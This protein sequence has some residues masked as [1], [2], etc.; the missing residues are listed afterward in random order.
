MIKII[1]L[2]LLC[3]L[4]MFLSGCV[5]YLPPVADFSTDIS[6]GTAPLTVQF[7]DNS[8]DPDGYI[9]SW[10]WDFD[11]GNTS[12]HQEGG[13]ITHTFQNEGSYRVKLTV[14]D[15]EGHTD[16]TYSYV[17]VS[18]SSSMESHT[19]VA[20]I[21]AYVSQNNPENNYGLQ[22]FLQV[23]GNDYIYLKFTNI[24][25]IET[26]ISAKLKLYTIYDLTNGPEVVVYSC[27]DNTWVENNITWNAKPDYTS[28]VIDRVEVNGS[29][30]WFTWDIWDLTN[31]VKDA[32]NDSA[33]TLVLVGSTSQ[34]AR[35]FSIESDS[36]YTP[37][38]EF[39]IEP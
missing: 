35:F 5:G 38:I 31:N 33:I 9:I 36:I 34:I 13:N 29:Q 11:D 15:N 12:T 23:S 20:S 14:T 6:E 10:F 39:Q 1:I 25:A 2:S 27:S 17:N 24:P 16:D 28:G 3:V 4:S 32:I 18:S 37:K 7:T 30:D 22:T 26:I 8:Y 19:L 21:D